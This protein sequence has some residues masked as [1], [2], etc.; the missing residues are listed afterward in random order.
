V[1]EGEDE[2]PEGEEEA[3]KPADF[4]PRGTGVNEFT[5]WVTD[6]VFGKWT[7]LPDIYPSDIKAAR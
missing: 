3:E 5:Y 4:E 7:K 2:V 1:L 6:G